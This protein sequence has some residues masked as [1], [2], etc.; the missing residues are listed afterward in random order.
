MN[1]NW[2]ALRGIGNLQIMKVTLLGPFLPFLFKVFDGLAKSEGLAPYIGQLETGW[3]YTVF[4]PLYLFYFGS[5]FLG[6]AS[7][8]YLLV[9]PDIVKRHEDAVAYIDRE[10]ATRIATEA[11]N[12]NQVK[13]E[14][15]ATYTQADLSCART[16]KAIFALYAL[17]FILLFIPPIY[18]FGEVAI[19]VGEAVVTKIFLR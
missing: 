4:W 2:S 3:P 1:C 12:P 19:N 14:M 16:R 13:V 6:V 15:R 17:G 7:A 11:G 8:A 10:S 5:T 9:C 18:R